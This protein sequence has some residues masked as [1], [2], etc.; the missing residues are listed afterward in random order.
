M[1]QV[2][3]LGETTKLMSA[4]RNTAENLAADVKE[5]VA[6]AV[7]AVEAKVEKTVSSLKKK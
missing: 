7:D 1:I 6:A 2:H 5:G 3:A 4:K